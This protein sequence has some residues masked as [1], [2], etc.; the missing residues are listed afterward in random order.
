MSTVLVST[1]PPPS[2]LSTLS[3]HD[4][5]PISLIV[6]ASAF[7]LAGFRA[8]A[9]ADDFPERVRVTFIDGEV[10]LDMSNEE[11]EKSTRLNSTNSQAPYALNCL[12]KNRKFYGDGVLL[13]NEAGN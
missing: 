6:P 12:I 13:S 8:W 9:T 1:P 11:D 3:L 10:F 2:Q 7:T 5:L 4:A